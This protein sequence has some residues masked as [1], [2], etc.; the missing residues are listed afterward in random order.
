MSNSSLLNA[1]GKKY[2]TVVTVLSINPLSGLIRARRALINLLRELPI[3]TH[4]MRLMQ[5]LFPRTIVMG[6]GRVV[7]EGIK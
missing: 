6:E 2:I 3:T 7:T 1:G 5:E 4:D